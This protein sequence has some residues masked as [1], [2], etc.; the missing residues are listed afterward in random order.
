MRLKYNENMW[1]G[2]I[3]LWRVA[4]IYSANGKLV[5]SSEGICSVQLLLFSYHIFIPNIT[6]TAISVFICG[7]SSCVISF[8]YSMER[9]TDEST[10]P[11]YQDP[12]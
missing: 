3:C 12:L 7:N 8:I 11:D 5:I 10:N 1:T 2:F 9:S 4:G 6:T